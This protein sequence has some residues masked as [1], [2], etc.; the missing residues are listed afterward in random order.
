M[1]PQILDPATG[2]PMVSKKPAN[3]EVNKEDKEVPANKPKIPLPQ[4]GEILLAAYVNTINTDNPDNK[5]HI[6]L[7]F[8]AHAA[9][10]PMELLNILNEFARTLQTAAQEQMANAIAVAKPEDIARLGINKP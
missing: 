9:L 3:K 2:K 8:E 1:N 10:S 6:T 4:E 5:R 7:R